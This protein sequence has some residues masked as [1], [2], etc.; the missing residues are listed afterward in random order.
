MEMEEALAR[1][2]IQDVLWTYARGVDRG[3]LDAMLAAYHPEAVDH[4]C[5]F[6]GP[7]TEFV[8]QVADNA[9]AIPAVGQ[10]HITNILVKLS[11]PDDALVESYFL[12]FHP[13]QNGDTIRLSIVAGRYLD[14]FQRRDGAWKILE[15]QVV[16][17]WTREHIE[18][19]VSPTADAKPVQGLKWPQDASYGFFSSSPN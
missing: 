19:A 16:M 7:A 17:D 9:Q 13:H 5:N 12:A 14:H 10:H 1:L 18:G 15:R 11:G 6:S 3:D 4:H 8:R 2:E